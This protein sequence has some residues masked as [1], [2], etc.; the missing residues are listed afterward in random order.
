[1]RRWLPHI[2]R[3]GV[4][5]ECVND[6]EGG[7][8]G[9]YFGVCWFGFMAEVNFTSIYAER[10]DMARIRSKIEMERTA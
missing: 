9:W 4:S 1:M 7:R 10:R 2:H 8:E 6:D 5:S 3:G